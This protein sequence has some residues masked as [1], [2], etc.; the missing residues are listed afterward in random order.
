MKKLFLSIAF[1]LVTF[2]WVGAQRIIHD[3]FVEPRSI[4]NFHAVDVSSGIDLYL[5][6]GDEAIAVSG[7]SPEYT[8]NIRTV[9]TKGVLKIWYDD[10][11]NRVINNN[12]IALKVYL[13][14]KS[15][16]AITASSGS[17]VLVDGT[18]SVPSLAIN[19]SS[20]SDFK[21]K[22]SIND[23]KI[24]QS[25]GA[26][27]AIEGTV[28]NLS[29]EISSGSDLNGYGLE[30]QN[31][32]VSASGGST[33]KIRATKTITATVSG[34]SDVLYKGDAT[35]SRKKSVGSSVKKVSR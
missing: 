5:S 30:S 15:L 21:G 18:L 8:A 29:I 10:N 2:I 4:E 33:V 28:V 34:G 32:S 16:D 6:G 13:S 17:D 25:S 20:G 31:C 7:G 9:V 11:N 27:V 14:Y 24:K 22:V 19:I 1:L 23:L 12:K 26:D 35:L 3:P